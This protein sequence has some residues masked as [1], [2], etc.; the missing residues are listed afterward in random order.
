MKTFQKYIYK[1]FI[2]DRKIEV[3]KV[4]WN[5]KQLGSKKK[6]RIEELIKIVEIPEVPYE[7]FEQV[8]SG[9]DWGTWSVAD[10]DYTYTQKIKRPVPSF[11]ENEVNKALEGFNREPIEVI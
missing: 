3:Y 8:C 1:L 4:I 9:Y 10:R 2:K 11:I 7:E 5:S 6:N